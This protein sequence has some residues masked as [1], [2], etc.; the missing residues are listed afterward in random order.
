MTKGTITVTSADAEKLRNLLREA[1]ATDYR[2]SPYLTHLRGEL[3]RARIVEPHQI[4]MDVVTMHSTVVLRDLES[5]ETSTWMLVFP[6]EADLETGKL[7]VL[8]PIGTAVLGY[9]AGDMFTWDTPSGACSMRVEKVL[10]QP[11]AASREG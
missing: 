11:E 1:I 8:A 9:R 2:S 6:E 5:G 4:E 3:D 10:F 7:S